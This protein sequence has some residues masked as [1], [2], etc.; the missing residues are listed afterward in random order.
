MSSPGFPY[1]LESCELAMSNAAANIADYVE[2]DKAACIGIVQSY[3][4]F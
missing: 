4:P 1:T 2:G 3:A